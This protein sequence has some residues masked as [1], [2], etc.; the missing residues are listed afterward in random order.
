MRTAAVGTT[1]ISKWLINILGTMVYDCGTATVS[2]SIVKN[3][4]KGA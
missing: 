4:D 3:L 2:L 1:R